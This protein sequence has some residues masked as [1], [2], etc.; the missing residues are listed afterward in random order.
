MNTNPRTRYIFSIDFYGGWFTI[1]RRNLDSYTGDG[2]ASSRRYYKV[3][4]AT[5]SRLSRLVESWPN[6]IYR[7]FRTSDG[8]PHIRFEIRQ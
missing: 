5:A 4:P 7:F 3:T 1:W 8:Q 2:M 6:V